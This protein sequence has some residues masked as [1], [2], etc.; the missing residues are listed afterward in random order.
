MRIITQQSIVLDGTD[1]L[2]LKRTV[3]EMK[4]QA[5]SLDNHTVPPPA[6]TPNQPGPV[7][8]NIAL[9]KKTLPLRSLGKACFRRLPPACREPLAACLLA[10]RRLNLPTQTST[11]FCKP[12][13]STYQL[14]RRI[15]S[16]KLASEYVPQHVCTDQI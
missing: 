2:D 10:E 15:G 1:V 9:D 7:F 6:P 16:P 5:D 14:R 3:T 13:M 4:F 8:P 12:K 11:I